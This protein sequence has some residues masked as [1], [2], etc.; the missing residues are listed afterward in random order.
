MQC[1]AFLAA[2]SATA[3]ATA[4]P[5][6]APPR[7]DPIAFFTGYTEGTGDMTIV[8]HPPAA[9]AV[10]GHGTIDPDGTLVLTQRVE[11]YGKPARRREW[12]IRAVAPGHYTGTL[13]D[14]VGP[15]TGE[16]IGDR[17]HLGYRMK[18]N[19]RVDQWLTL[20][21]DGRSAHNVMRVRK[22]GVPVARL[23]ET[24]RR[25]GG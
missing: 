3:L 21:A 24:I 4:T 1:L 25:T 9:M 13:S 8:M 12:R 2:V 19:L 5:A 11:R 23:D 18:G 17:V 20:A 6:A 14:A 16:S 7:F 22:R 15:V 10:H